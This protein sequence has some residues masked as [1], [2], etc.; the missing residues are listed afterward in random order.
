MPLPS[1]LSRGVKGKRE[2]EE[3]NYGLLLSTLVPHLLQVVVSGNREQAGHLS[4]P[5]H[6]RKR[7]TGSSLP[8]IPSNEPEPIPPSSQNT[9][10]PRTN[11]DA[12]ENN[13]SHLSPPCPTGCSLQPPGTG[14]FPAAPRPSLQG[15]VVPHP[16]EMKSLFAKVSHGRRRIV[17]G[18]PQG[19][20]EL[21]SPSRWILPHPLQT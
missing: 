9:L 3:P 15:S 7:I 14:S 19:E 17:R 21:A 8:S 11:T 13:C 5:T 12:L 20:M 2:R 10:P 18:S 16:G 6:L 1:I 4:H